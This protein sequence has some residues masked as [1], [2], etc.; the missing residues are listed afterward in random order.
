MFGTDRGENVIAVLGPTDTENEPLML[1]T[2]N[3]VCKRVDGADL[4]EL[5]SGRPVIKLKVRDRVIAAFPAA[6]D[7]DILIV[8]SAAQALRTPAAGISLQ[9]PSAGGVAGMKLRGN[10]KVVGAGVVA[11]GDEVILTVSD[12]STAKLTDSGELTAQGRGGNGVRL[13]KFRDERR[14]DLAWVGPTEGALTIVG[15]EAN[16]TKADNTPAPLNLRHTRRDGASSRT[17]RRI[18]DAGQARW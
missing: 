14:L 2:A 15:T 1:V 8:S 9:G 11:T 13:T 3:G 16:P 12:T 5:R 7:A 4:T 6:D 18:I 10:A 17:S